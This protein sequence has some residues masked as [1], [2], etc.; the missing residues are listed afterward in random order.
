MIVEPMSDSEEPALD[1]D[2]KLVEES[3][4][5]IQDTLVQQPG[6]DYLS[7]RETALLGISDNSTSNSTK[8]NSRKSDEVFD[9]HIYPCSCFSFLNIFN[10][11][12]CQ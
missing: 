5:F 8:V 3:K 9:I 6:I 1:N 4:P 10:K 12:K 2:I 7:F 11:Q